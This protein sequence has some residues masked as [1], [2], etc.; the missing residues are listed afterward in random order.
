MGKIILYKVCLNSKREG[1]IISVDLNR[2][3]AKQNSR[4]DIYEIDKNKGN[5][6]TKYKK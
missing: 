5:Y 2:Y 1:K 3:S 4:K 6:N